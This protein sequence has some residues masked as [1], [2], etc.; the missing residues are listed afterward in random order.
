MKIFS[1]FQE[2][3]KPLRE[4]NICLLCASHLLSALLAYLI[5]SRP[6]EIVTVSFLQMRK[7]WFVV[8]TYLGHLG[9]VAQCHVLPSRLH[10]GLCLPGP[11]IPRLLPHP[12]CSQGGQ[13]T[14]QLWQSRPPI[15][16][17]SA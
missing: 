7:C 11:T 14:T 12:Q 9:Q 17:S 15:N 16:A 1:V 13:Q 3:G 2:I 5:L 8:F 4:E 10:V 6:Y